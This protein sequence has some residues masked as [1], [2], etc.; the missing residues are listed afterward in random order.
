MDLWEDLVSLVQGGV[1]AV[2]AGLTRV[3]GS[4]N[5]R[6][7]REMTPTLMAICALEPEMMKLSDADLRRKTDEYRE[8]YHEAMKEP[9]RQAEAIS[10]EEEARKFLQRESQRVL[11][12]L[13]VEAFATMREAARRTLPAPNPD[14][15]YP[16]MRHFDVQILG[17]IVLHQGKIAEMVTGEGKTL[18]ATCPAYLN[19]LTGRGVH[20]VTTNDYLARVGCEWMRPTYE[21]LGMTAGAIQAHQPYDEKRAAYQCDI[22]FG[23]N[24]E[25]GFDY[26]RDN[27]RS[28][29]EDQVQRDL[30][31]AIVDEVDS[32][33]IDEARVP[34]IISG[35]AEDN[36]EMFK[37]ADQIARVLR[38][39]VHFEIKEKE[40]SAQL[41][42]EGV[43]EVQ[44]RL[45]VDNI[46]DARNMDWPHLIEQALRA[47]HLYKREVDYVVKGNEIVIV[48]EF[49]GRLQEGRRW[50]DGLHQAIEAKERIRVREENQTLATITYQNFFLLYDKLAGMT[51]TAITEAAE[52]DKIYGL[53]VVVVPTNR[54]LIRKSYPDVVFRTAKEKW[55]AI[56]DEIVSVHRT[57]RPI[58]VGT[59]SIENSEMLSEM[60]SKRGIEHEVLNAKH[61]ARE[62]QIVAKAGQMGRVTIATNMAGR[63]TDIVLGPGVADLCGIQCQPSLGRWNKVVDKVAKH[64]DS[65]WHV[66]WRV[67]GQT[68]DGHMVASNVHRLNFVDELPQNKVEDEAGAAKPPKLEPNEIVL[69]HPH[70][71][72]EIV[73][74]NRIP[75]F[76]WNAG[77]NVALFQLQFGLSPD[78]DEKPPIV[79]Y[80]RKLT[81]LGEEIFK[82]GGLHVVGSER[83]EA[84]RIDNQLRGRAGRQG[85]PGSSRF[86]LSLED[87]LMRVFA[88]ERVSAI[89]KRFGMEEGMAIEH[90]MVS[91]SIERAQRKREEYNFEI[92]KNLLEFDAPMNEQRKTIYAWR[93]AVLKG[94]NLRE[95]VW[96]MIEATVQDSV[97]FYWENR[98]EEGERDIQG[99][100]EWFEKKFGEPIELPAAEDTSPEELE[101]LLLE[102]AKKIYDAKE[103]AVGPEAMRALEQFLLLDKIDTKWKDHL[104][105]MDRLRDG[106]GLRGYGQVDP[107][108]EFKKESVEAF[109][110]MIE[111]IRE[112]VTDFIFKVEFE[113]DAAMERGSKWN[114]EEFLYE[115]V[116][117]FSVTQSNQ[118]VIDNMAADEKQ[119]PIRVADKIPRNAPCPCGS[120]KKYKKCCGRNA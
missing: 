48:D 61:H 94:E 43:E 9:R 31:F 116:G 4:R 68:A 70:D 69:Q 73:P 91:R 89:L 16:M 49:T 83:H 93:Q 62:A 105:A 10:D 120:G 63:G 25:F 15:P 97:D 46:Y 103:A 14:N 32:I 81:R 13:L 109:D 95:R 107:K 106:I 98:T 60:L 38:P 39:E 74:E 75:T 6:L 35:P 71:N 86:F 45:G 117:N 44:R 28:S 55:R 22:T 36:T 8:R 47:H 80:P 50:S 34:L 18:V 96:E 33:L 19:A 112:E 52:F 64:M 41:T 101:E 82:G 5:E 87:D 119:E 30:H 113:V 65:N 56:V 17:G 40:N 58:L 53:D 76:S 90:P 21:L 26:L 85:D 118:E 108:I 115:D 84:R 88:S 27:M 59:T 100:A 2:M 92:R 23:Q 24:S 66:Y 51:G 79:T 37:R 72:E 114:P 104:Y 54:P 7:L 99:L 57:G 20:I 102:K 3:F 77:R 12:G 110:M 78:F 11:D 111:S 42:E 67:V 1:N 29:L